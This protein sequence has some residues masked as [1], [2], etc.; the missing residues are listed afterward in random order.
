MR[1]CTKQIRTHSL[2][3]TNEKFETVRGHIECNFRNRFAL[4]RYCG[5]LMEHL[6]LQ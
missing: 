4:E 1:S 2:L 5:I 6:V 3:F